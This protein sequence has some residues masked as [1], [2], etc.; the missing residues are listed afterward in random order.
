M[1]DFFEGFDFALHCVV[2]KGATSFARYE[3]PAQ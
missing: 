2:Q 1:S 3:L